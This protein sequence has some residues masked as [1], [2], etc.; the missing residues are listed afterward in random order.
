MA[1]AIGKPLTLDLATKERR[2][3]LYARICVELNVT[4][5]MLYE[6]T[7]NLGAVGC[8]ISIS[9]SPE[10]VIL[11]MLLGILLESVL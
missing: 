10:N 9:V 8:R 7:V 4:S 3:L 11:V 6:I 1:S 5:N 2:R